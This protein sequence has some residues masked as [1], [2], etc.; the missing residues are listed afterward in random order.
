MVLAVWSILSTLNGPAV[1]GI[2]FS[3]PVLKASGVLVLGR[4]QRANSDFQS[5][6]GLA[7]VTTTSLSS[8]P[9]WTL[10]MS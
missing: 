3:Q 7:N 2:L 5:A 1:T 8:L 6:K 9:R 10:S 4:V